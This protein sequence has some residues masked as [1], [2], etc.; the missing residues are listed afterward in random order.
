[1]PADE[2][3]LHDVVHG[4]A[5]MQGPGDVGQ[6]HHDD[7]ARGSPIGDRG[8]GVRGCP[9]FIDPLFVLG[10][11][12]QFRDFLGHEFVLGGSE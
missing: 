6:G 2:E 11:L 3:V 12:V 5:H 7:I 10:G 9:F 8:E 1:V 4:V